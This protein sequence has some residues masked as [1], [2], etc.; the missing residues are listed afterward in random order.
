MFSKNSTP[1]AV[2]LVSNIRSYPRLMAS[3]NRADIGS[4]RYIQSVSVFIVGSPCS[5]NVS[6]ITTTPDITLLVTINS[7]FSSP[8]HVVTLYLR[9]VHIWAMG[10]LC[11]TIVLRGVHTVMALM[12]G[13]THTHSSILFDSGLI[14]ILCKVCATV[15]QH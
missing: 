8:S 14:S 2:A 9:L 12:S 4:P 13:G 1:P 3:P 5:R 11:K 15:G 7:W 6:R 10:G